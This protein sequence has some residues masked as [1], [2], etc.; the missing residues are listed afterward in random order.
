[1]KYNLYIIIL[2]LTAFS[3]GQ[4]SLYVNLRTK[5]IIVKHPEIQ[6]D[7]FSIQPGYFKIFSANQQEIPPEDY[8]IDFVDARL[9]LLNYPAYQNREITVEYLVYPAYLRR[10]YQRYNPEI[11]QQDTISA[12]I[13]LEEQV[14]TPKPLEGLQTQGHITRGFNAG[15]NQSLVMQSGMDLKIE[16]NLSKKLKIKAVL[17]DDNL[18][19]AYA[20]ISQSYKEFDRIYMQL[21]AP[22]WQATGG[23]LQLN[24]QQNY[25]LKFSRK[26]Q[27]I[28]LESGKDSSQIQVTGAY[29][30]GKYGINRFKGIEGNQGPYVLKGNHNE[31]YIFVIPG[32]EKVYINGHLL[33]KGKDKDYVIHYETAEIR[34]NPTYPISNNQRIVVEFN[35]SNQHY[36]RY[37]NYN[38]YRHK[39]KKSDFEFYT[40]IESDAKNKSLL[41][42]LNREQVDVLR[43]AGDNLQNMWVNAAQLTTYNENKILYK[44]TINGNLTYFEFT[45]EDLPE[46][47]EVRFSY[48]GKNQGNYKIKQIVANGKIFEYAGENQGDYIPYIK[49]TA[50]VNKKYAG[51]NF[52]FHPNEK[53]GISLQSL[54]S[55]TDENLF[56]NRD[57]HNNTG[58]A[59]HLKISQLL[60]QKQKQ[61]L[62]A[63]LQ[64]D[65]THQ[66][67]RALDPYRPVEFKRQWQIDTIFGQQHLLDFGLTYQ[68]EKQSVNTGFRYYNLRDTIH[69]RQGYW[70]SNW[71]QNKWQSI[72]DFQYTTQQNQGDLQA[73]NLHQEWLYK[74]KKFIISA[75]GH[76]EK[77]DRTI[78]SAPDSLNYR[79]RYGEI[80]WSNRDTTAFSYN[81]FYRREQND[82]IFRQHF[83]GAQTMDITGFS[84]RKKKENYRLQIFTQ[85]KHLKR[86]EKDSIHNYLNIKALWQQFYFNK[87]LSTQIQIESFNGNTLRDEVVFV[88]TP[89]GQG[90]HQWNDYNGNGIQEINEFEVAVYADQANYIRVILPSKNYIPTLNNRYAGQITINPEVWAGKSFLKKIYGIMRF[91]T[92]HETV[93][94]GKDF[95][96]QWQPKDNLSENTVWQQDWFLNR[97]R[98]KYHLH[99]SYQ[100]LEQKQL[101]LV[102]Q[103]AHQLEQYQLVSKH[104]FSRYWTWKQKLNHTHSLNQSENYTQQNY[105]IDTQEMEEG[106]EWKAQKANRLYTYFNYKN[107]ENL[108]GNEQLK[109]YQTGLKYYYQ[110]KK[111][112]ILNFDLKFIQNKMQGNAYSPVAFQMLEGLQA[113]KNLV[114]TTMLRQKLNSYLVMNLT[115]GLRLSETHHAVHT[116]S[117][118]LKMIF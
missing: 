69:V 57:D 100:F 7:T 32:S 67:F 94:K 11:Y 65:Y 2:L 102:G 118:Q 59:F 58:G 87:F 82:S 81:I 42:D 4:D 104:Q 74:T 52:A 50:P 78:Q 106:I 66:N 61:S 26:T 15:N 112:N 73:Y 29:V 72:S 115:Y 35:Y 13:Q 111:E 55:N 9:L 54:L 109:M 47:Y 1:M 108:S 25:F 92:R 37:L 22:G 21:I 10:S 91:E 53:T 71:Q 45:T 28:S 46:L 101:L 99:F 97:A 110:T 116:G 90:T 43:N 113:G 31:S 3:Y 27:G 49:L 68:K 107:K 19:Q 96:L 70:Q 36:V 85:Y 6:I 24:E 88:E 12:G 30:E 62:S 89:P 63:N 16:G 51:F 75:T 117:I 86:Q 79:Y 14:Y 48:V 17:S 56:S 105:R 5:T 83:A 64:Y 76:L 40:F 39:S 98:K 34:F 33:Q 38:R 8:Q 44:K 60:L 103:Q 93:S 80:K 114:F 23:D 77:R 84:I 20:G 18:P 41:Y 95:P